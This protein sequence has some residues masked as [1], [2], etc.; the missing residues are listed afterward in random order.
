MKSSFRSWLNLAIVQIVLAL[1]LLLT[2]LFNTNSIVSL[3]N[4]AVTATTQIVILFVLLLLQQR[5][6]KK[7][8]YWC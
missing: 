8:C 4:V 5:W 1:S 3:I 6:L 2:T 7:Q